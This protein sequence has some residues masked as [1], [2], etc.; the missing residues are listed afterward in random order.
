MPKLKPRSSELKAPELKPIISE[1]KRKDKVPRKDLIAKAHH[2]GTQAKRHNGGPT[3]ARS[4]SLVDCWTLRA[5]A[6]DLR[7]DT[8]DLTDKAQHHRAKRFEKQNSQS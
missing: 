6:Q 2:L 1:M 7:A 4:R 3:K 8:Q 5:E